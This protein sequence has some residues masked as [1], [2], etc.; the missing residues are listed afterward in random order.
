L[1]FFS[2]LAREPVTQAELAQAFKAAKWGP[3][4]RSALVV[5]LQRTGQSRRLCPIP[6]VAILRLRTR[7]CAFDFLIRLVLTQG[8]DSPD[9]SRQPTY[10]SDLQNKTNNSRD[11]ATNGKK[12]GKRQNNR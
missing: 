6:R 3:V 8:I 4:V 10:H 11:R 9:G 12:Y 1:F 7:H 5:T 2:P